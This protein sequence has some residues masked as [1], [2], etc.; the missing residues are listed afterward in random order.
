MNKILLFFAVSMLVGCVQYKSTIPSDYAGELAT[1]EDTFQIRS[2]GSAFFYCVTKV[3]GNKVANAASE[4]LQASAGHTIYLSAL[5]ASRK[6]PVKPI[7]LFLVANVVHS[8]PIA[9]LI[10]PD[11]KNR[12]EGEIEFTPIPNMKYFVKGSLSK[13]YSSVWLED[14]NGNIVSNRIGTIDPS[15]KNISIENKVDAVVNG[16]EVSKTRA[17]IFL[18]I[19]GGE[20]VDSVIDK[21]GRPDSII[22]TK[23]SIFAGPPAHDYTTYEYKTLG[24]IQFF[25]VQSSLK[26][27]EKITK[28]VQLSKD[29]LS[30]KTKI[31]SAGS[32]EL[33]LL[34]KEYYSSDVPDVE[35]LDVIAEKIWQERNTKDSEMEDAMAYF[36]MILGKSGNARY[37][38]F[39]N[40][41]ASDFKSP[42][43]QKHAKKSLLLLPTID[44]EQFKLHTSS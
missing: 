15:I 20:S 13:K 42:K 38:S 10:D 22:E 29:S 37:R 2:S 40:L 4:S 24:K 6:I 33:R 34:A 31:D 18:G 9:Y 30:F 39:L 12:A 17:E 35:Y 32:S 11:A 41:V 25:G 28:G 3:A 7:K 1:I 8:A 16:K 14:S 26:T 19:A 5:G 43:I 27:V 36:C 23:A 21:L 44:V